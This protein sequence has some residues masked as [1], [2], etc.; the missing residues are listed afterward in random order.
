MASFVLLVLV[1][2]PLLMPL[3]CAG[4]ALGLALRASRRLPGSG[5]HL[6]SVTTCVLV[7]VMAGAAAFGAYA[8]GV[9]SGFYVLDPDQV[10][11]VRGLPGD[12]IVTRATLPISAQCVTEGGLAAELVPGWVNPVIIGGLA[13]FVLALMAGI[14]AVT[15]RRARGHHGD[16]TGSSTAALQSRVSERNHV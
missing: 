12:R 13:L 1:F 7:M 2:A 14:L 6:P 4:A 5:W 11:A 10:C 16:V 9:M 8:W 15:R 3:V